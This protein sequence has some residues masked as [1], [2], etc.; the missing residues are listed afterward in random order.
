MD[1]KKTETQR[2]SFLGQAH[3]KRTLSFP[4]IISRPIKKALQRHPDDPT[5]SFPKDD[6]TVENDEI[7]FEI[8]FVYADRPEGDDEGDSSDSMGVHADDDGFP[9]NAKD[10]DHGDESAGECID[11]DI[12]NQAE[13]DVHGFESAGEHAGD[14]ILNQ[15]EEDDDDI[16][17]QAE[18]D[19]YGDESAGE[20]ID[21]D[22]LNQAEE[23]V[24]GHESAFEDTD[25][26]PE[27]LAN[28]IPRELACEN[29]KLAFYSPLQLSP[30]PKEED[31]SVDSEYVPYALAALYL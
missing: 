25:T 22:I 30:A 26:V 19:G 15:A 20:H 3:H 28:G 23:D 24:H 27:P 13:K 11:G 17:N 21:D 5:E 8:A 14:D 7:R 4:A 12:L 29:D 9:N 31:G 16:L 18:E 1:E 10:E 2:S 6:D